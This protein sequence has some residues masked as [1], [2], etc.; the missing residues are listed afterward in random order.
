MKIEIEKVEKIKEVVNIKL[1]YYT[2]WHKT[3]FYKV[4]GSGTFDCLR[5]SESDMGTTLISS[6][7]SNSVE[8]TEA[9]FNEAFLKTQQV[10]LTAFNK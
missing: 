3:I 6:A 9:E 8:I 4:Y 5:V 7:F 1:P 2:C 10:L